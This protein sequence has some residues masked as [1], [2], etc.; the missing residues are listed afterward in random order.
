MS[1]SRRSFLHSTAAAAAGLAGAAYSGQAQGPGQA[2]GQNAAPPKPAAEIQVPKIK[3]GNVEISRM[4]AGCNPFYGYGHFNRTMDNVMTEWCTPDRVCSVLHQ[5]NRFGINAYN[6]ITTPRCMQDFERFQAEGGQMHL[7]V[8]G[9][10]DPTVVM[11]RF[12]P[13]AIYAQGEST[14]RSFLTAES[15]TSASIARRSGRRARW[16]GWAAI[17]PR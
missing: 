4:V 9:G 6:F 3:F 8:Q 13:L 12:K 16:W 10:G 5:C 1:N 2:P 7:I 17:I 14:D 11:K 15:T